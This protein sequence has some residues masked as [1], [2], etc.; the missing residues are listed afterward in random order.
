MFR[1]DDTKIIKPIINEA[2]VASSGDIF[3]D[4][5]DLPCLFTRCVALR[6]IN[7]SMSAFVIG[8]KTNNTHYSKLL[9]TRI[10]I[11][12]G[13]FFKLENVLTGCESE[14]PDCPCKVGIAPHY[15]NSLLHSWRATPRVKKRSR[16]GK[17]Y[18]LFLKSNTKYTRENKTGLLKWTSN[19][20]L[21]YILN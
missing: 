10:W 8:E 18:F 21:N 6:H 9:K 17:N 15:R 7:I 1:T 19:L 2:F 12:S 14:E 16:N 4:Y 5:N 11:D 20:N 3:T 13:K